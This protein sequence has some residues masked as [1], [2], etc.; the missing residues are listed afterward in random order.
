MEWWN[1]EF[2][3]YSF[4]VKMSSFCTAMFVHE[5]IV[6]SYVF[7]FLFNWKR[8]S[9]TGIFL[10]ILS[11][12]ADLFIEHPRTA[13][14]KTITENRLRNSAQNDKLCIISPVYVWGFFWKIGWKMLK[15]RPC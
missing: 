11:N 14:S 13:A 7:I 3:V 8:N 1:R 10:W 15:I 2:K 5:F 6:W 9:D 4:V 12:I